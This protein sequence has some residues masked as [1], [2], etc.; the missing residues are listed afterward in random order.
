MYDSFADELIKI[1]GFK[2][3]WERGAEARRNA[4]IGAAIGLPV[5]TALGALKGNKRFGAVVGGLLGAHGGLMYTMQQA[6]RRAMQK[7]KTAAADFAKGLPS[8]GVA[9]KIPQ[10]S[11][12]EW[13]MNIQLHEAQRAGK[14]WDM[15][16][17]DPKRPVAY[18]WAVPKAQM[19]AEIGDKVLAVR[20]PDHRASYM[21]WSGDLETGYGAGTVKSEFHEPVPIKETNAGKIKFEQDGKSYTLHRTGSKKNWLLR[22]TG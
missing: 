10:T 21:G 18:S 16:F 4:L 1:A 19:P 11:G 12:G 17:E 6:G 14:H 7:K 5:G 15:R 22:R 2:E 20:Q 13:N 3:K 9:R 8:K